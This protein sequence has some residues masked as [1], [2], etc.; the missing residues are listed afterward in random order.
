LGTPEKEFSAKYRNI[1]ESV[2]N[3]GYHR[4]TVI[5]RELSDD[6]EHQARRIIHQYNLGHD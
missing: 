4:F 6:Y 2:E 5:P 3:Q 1:A